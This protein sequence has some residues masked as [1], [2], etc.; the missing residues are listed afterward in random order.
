MENDTKKTL[1]MQIAQQIEGQI[2][3]KQLRPGDKIPTENDLVKQYNV[4]RM[5]ARNALDL[6]VN[7]NLIERFPGRGSFVIDNTNRSNSSTNI[8]QTIGVIVPKIAPSFGMELLSELSKTADANNFN[9]LYTETQ[10]NSFADEARAIQRMRQVAQGLIVWPIP[11]KVI[12]NEILKLIIDN[13]P[14]VLLDRY[15]KDVDASYIVTNNQTATTLALEH[16]VK[17]GHKHICLVPKENVTDTSIQDRLNS[18]KSF[19]ETNEK[20][21]WT[22]LLTH[23]INY[24]DAEAV[25][26]EKQ[27]LMESIKTLLAEHPQTTAFFVTE[28]YPATLLYEALTELGYQVPKDFSIVCYDSPTFFGDNVV[29]FTHIQQDEPAI[30]KDAFNML[31]KLM[32]NKRDTIQKFEKAKLVLGDTT[33][34]APQ[35]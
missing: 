19:I 1:Y 27:N 35:R 17:L 28:Y 3:S 8:P 33:G 10:N 4:S 29:H 25:S 20:A 12:G 7:K 2:S 18:A 31:L 16:I 11:G 13:Y 26:H 14:V 24:N 9:L 23:G 21:D 15:I 32:D 34:P 6:L 22:M 5:T 30:A